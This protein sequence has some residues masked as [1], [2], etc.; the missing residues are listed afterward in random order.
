MTA[1][2][3][4]EE[5]HLSKSLLQDWLQTPEALDIDLGGM[6]CHI[7][8]KINTFLTNSLF[9]HENGKLDTTF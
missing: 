9:P 7:V 5:Y 4:Q 3:T 2:E 1:V 8:S 6:G